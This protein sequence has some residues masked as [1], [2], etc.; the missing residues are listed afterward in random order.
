MV[1]SVI[2][3]SLLPTP[4]IPADGS[5]FKDKYSGL[6]RKIVRKSALFSGNGATKQLNDYF[7]RMEFSL[8]YTARDFTAELPASEYTA[9][10]R[11]AGG[12]GGYCRACPNYG[13]SWD[14]RLS[15]ST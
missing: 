15:D 2:V 1:R 12:S 4:P 6:F 11:D 10:F 14:A 5:G 13:N 7:C 3:K 9:R 8:R